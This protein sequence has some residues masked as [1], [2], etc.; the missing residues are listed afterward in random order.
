MI[1][2]PGKVL[3]CFSSVKELLGAI[4]PFAAVGVAG[5]GQQRR[6]RIP[7]R[8]PGAAG[9]YGRHRRQ[10]S[11]PRHLSAPP[12]QS[13]AA[14][15]RVANVRFWR[16]R[17]VPNVAPSAAP[18]ALH[19]PPSVMRITTRASHVQGARPR[20]LTCLRSSPWRCR[21]PPPASMRCMQKSTDSEI[22][23]V[24]ASAALVSTRA[25]RST[26]RVLW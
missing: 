7:G 9:K 15:R 23:C 10:N 1:F 11:Y 19:V 3:L 4:T 6:H 22:G 18:S 20:R 12:P 21:T 8:C 24:A 17:M 26:E 13:H 25:T 16:T 14:H 2:T 5:A